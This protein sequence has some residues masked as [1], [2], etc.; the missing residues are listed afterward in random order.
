MS[1]ECTECGGSGRIELFSSVVDCDC[2]KYGAVQ[3]SISGSHA[4]VDRNGKVT[5]HPGWQSSNGEVLGIATT[6]CKAGELLQVDLS[7]T[8]QHF[9]QEPIRRRINPMDVKFTI[10]GRL[11]TPDS[12]ADG[13]TFEVHRK[14]DESDAELIARTKGAVDHFDSAAM[15]PC[16]ARKQFAVIPEG[17]VCVSMA[18]P[19]GGEATLV[20]VNFGLETRAL[21]PENGSVYVDGHVFTF[22]DAYGDGWS[23]GSYNLVASM[24]REGYEAWMQDG[25]ILY[26]P[27]PQA[28]PSARLA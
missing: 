10:G 7:S 21:T 13:A 8:A 17:V 25:L 12:F 9:T 2:A 20:K 22:I 18:D 23:V 24:R 11:I 5:L 15:D 19:L 26:T 3:Q 16:E 6:P 14:P 27:G 1:M 4:S 28:D